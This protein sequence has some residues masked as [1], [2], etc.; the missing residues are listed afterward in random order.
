MS[1]PF[2]CECG[3]TFHVKGELGGRR[4]KYPACGRVSLI[5]KKAADS[6][7]AF[8]G[9]EKATKSNQPNAVVAVTAE[10]R[11]LFSCPCGEAIWVTEELAGKKAKCPTCRAVVVVP[12]AHAT[13]RTEKRQPVRGV[14]AATPQYVDADPPPTGD[15]LCSERTHE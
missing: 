11:I 1:I 13:S 12:R 14:R 6:G 4:G 3:K 5:P 8:E 2:T 10:G 9:Q 15:G 7:L